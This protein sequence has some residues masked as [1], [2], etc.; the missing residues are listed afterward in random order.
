MPAAQKGLLNNEALQQIR[1]YIQEDIKA[2]VNQAVKESADAFQRISK[3]SN[4]QFNNTFK[5]EMRELKSSIETLNIKH[6]EEMQELRA[7]IEGESLTSEQ[8]IAV[9]VVSLTKDYQNY[10]T[11]ASAREQCQASL[12]DYILSQLAHREQRDRLWSIKV[13]NVQCPWL[14]KTPTSRQVYDI[15]IKPV[16][17]E[18]DPAANV[19]YDN[20]IEYSHPLSQRVKGPRNYIFRFY[21]RHMLFQ[22]MLHKKIHLQTID[23]KARDKSGWS[24]AAAVAFDGKKYLKCS[25]DLCDV[26]RS[27]MTY[28]HSSGIATRTKLSGTSV[29]FMPKDGPMRW[30]KVQ[31]SMARS[32]IGLITPPP[33]LQD[34]VSTDNLVLKFMKEN[35]QTN[36]E[37][38]F[39][40]VEAEIKSL[41]QTLKDQKAVPAVQD[42][43]ELEDS[44]QHDTSVI[45]A[46]DAV[47]ESPAA[48]T[49]PV[50][51]PATVP[52]A[53]SSSA[54][55]VTKSRSSAATGTTSAATTTG[56]TSTTIS[57]RSAASKS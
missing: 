28:L 17:I 25:H 18:Q 35:G 24:A 12:N 29:A 27:V 22:F 45:A 3:V 13:N 21:S 34:I 9:R 36:R 57:T 23:R 26:N 38:Y 33:P 31:N 7:I 44:D 1:G 41:L 20:V 8:E 30:V 55:S 39:Q 56:T 19:S 46:N 50:L 16:L 6:R 54:A 52:V 42:H 43:A 10:V 51:A 53:K 11:N 14:E 4:D 2:A 37:V 15:I 48:E 49:A 5:N 32:H 47:A 40:G